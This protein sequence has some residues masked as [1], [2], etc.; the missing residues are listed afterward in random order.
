M[1]LVFL[2][3]SCVVAYMFV[4]LFTVVVYLYTIVVVYCCCL[5]VYCCCLHVCLFVYSCC[6]LVYYCCC[7]FVIVYLL[8]LF[9]CLF[10]CLIFLSLLLSFSLD[11]VNSDLLVILLQGSEI[12]TGLGEL[13]LLHTL[14][15]IPVDE[16]TL[17]V[18]QIELVVKTSPG[19]SDGGG[20]AQHADGTLYLGQVTAGNNGGWLVVDSHLESSWAP[21]DELDGPL[22]LD[23]GNGGVDI[24]GDDISSVQH[25]ACH[26]LAVTGI[27][28]HHLVGGLKDSVGDLSNGELLV[29]GLLSRDDWGIG[30][31][32]EM[33][34][35]VGH[36]VGLELGQID[37]EGTIEP[38]RGSD[39]ADD[40]SDQTVKV[41]VGWALD[42]QVTTA[43]VVDG[44]VV[45][46]EGAVGVLKGGMGGQDGV[47]G[48]NNSG[49]DLGGWVDSELQLGLL[50]VINGEPLHE[51]GGEARAGTS[52]EGVEK[53]ESLETSTLIGQF[54]DTVEYKI[55]DLLS[56]GVVTTGVVVGSILLSGDEL[57]GVEKL[58]VGSGTDLINYGWLQI[59]EDGTGYVLASSGLTEEGVEGIITTSDGLVRGHLAIRLDSVLQTVQ[60]PA[61]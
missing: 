27:A 9:T 45:N 15:Y 56:D 20:V 6:L 42:V 2:S 60:L 11:G 29:V 24:L 55:D 33:D 49:G 21:V 51:E 50:S 37:V 28:F 31:Q 54:P 3:L 10:V 17:G 40:L 59:D 7:L 48:L 13:S 1:S 61:D 38:Q 8:L 4:Y 22:G 25:T 16:G 47:V 5:F 53:E 35:W 58:T 12:L 41:G 46:H 44:L 14:S 34:T 26:V 32:R 18:H 36:Q 57:L 39:G 23:G 43:D 19:L 52:T 30:G